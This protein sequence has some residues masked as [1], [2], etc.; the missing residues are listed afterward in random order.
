MRNA[1]GKR[2]I[3]LPSRAMSEGKNPEDRYAECDHPRSAHSE[4][5]QPHCSGGSVEQP[6]PCPEF[7]EPER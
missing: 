4:Y 5:T 1:S 6:C 7:A 3:A 2:D